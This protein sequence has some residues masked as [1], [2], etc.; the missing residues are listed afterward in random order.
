M[1][2]R[3]VAAVSTVIEHSGNN[4]AGMFTVTADFTCVDSD[5]KTQVDPVC[6]CVSW[7]E[8]CKGLLCK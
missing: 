6:V 1:I 8:A 7:C 4:V 5:Y 2:K 3:F